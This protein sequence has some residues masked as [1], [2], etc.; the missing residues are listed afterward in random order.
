LL[1]L[2]VL[3]LAS[4]SLL[5]DILTAG[6]SVTTCYVTEVTNDDIWY[7]YRGNDGS[8]LS[9][10][11]AQ[12]KIDKWDKE[13]G[14]DAWWNFVDQYV[15]LEI[16]EDS[17]EWYNLTLWCKDN[18]LGREYHWLLKEIAQGNKSKYIANEKDTGIVK[19]R[20][21]LEHLGYQWVAD[22]GEYLTVPEEMAR[23]GLKYYKGRWVTQKELVVLKENERKQTQQVQNDASATTEELGSCRMIMDLLERR[24]MLLLQLVPGTIKV[25]TDEEYLKRIGLLR[26]ISMKRYLYLSQGLRRPSNKV[27]VRTQEREPVGKPLY[28]GILK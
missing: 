16:K 24:R 25:E 4:N 9:Y 14:R 3:F 15:K 23:R 8:P 22:F 28:L 2:F 19:A 20:A 21:T 10:R 5:A 13:G 1:V 12:D 18:G 17:I 6:K 11:T 27:T 7:Y 26:R